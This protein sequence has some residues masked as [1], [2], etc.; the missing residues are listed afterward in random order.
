MFDKHINFKFLF[1]FFFFAIVVISKAKNISIL[2]YISETNKTTIYKLREA[3]NTRK[4]AQILSKSGIS[5]NLILHVKFKRRSS[6]RKSAK[7]T[8]KPV[9]WQAGNYDWL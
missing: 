7:L 2:S 6:L 3:N 5:Q 1:C 9:R 4:S 8:G